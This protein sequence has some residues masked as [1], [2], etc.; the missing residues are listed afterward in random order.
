MRCARAPTA[1]LERKQDMKRR[2][3]ASP[4]NADA[5]ALTFAHPIGKADQRWKYGRPAQRESEDYDPLSW[6]KLYGRRSDY[7]A[8][9]DHVEPRAAEANV[10]QLAPRM[11]EE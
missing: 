4:D 3:L 6:D 5:L 11:R 1:F 7:A 10:A 2:G 9:C 8:L